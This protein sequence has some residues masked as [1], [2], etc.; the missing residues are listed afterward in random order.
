MTLV[1]S[2]GSSPGG[3]D[4]RSSSLQS[5]IDSYQMMFFTVFALLAA[6]AIIVFG[7]FPLAALR[8]LPRCP[9]HP[10]HRQLVVTTK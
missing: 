10:V 9:P 5:V 7:G 6:T 3:G 1:S 2:A 4:A 8:S